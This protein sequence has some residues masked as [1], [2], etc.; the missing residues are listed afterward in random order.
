M[1]FSLPDS[2]D[3]ELVYMTEAI[4]VGT[5]ADPCWKLSGFLYVS[6]DQVWPLPGPSIRAAQL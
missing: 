5:L 3:L 2:G 1:P 6:L 4:S